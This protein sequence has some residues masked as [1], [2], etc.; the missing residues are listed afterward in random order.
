MEF[1]VKRDFLP[2]FITNLF[3]VL[4]LGITIY[5]TY[6]IGIFLLVLAIVLGGAAIYNTAVIFATCRIEAD[7]LLFK[8]GLFKYEININDIV[9]VTPSKNCH[10]SLA[11]SFDRIRIL[12]NKGEKQ[13]VYYISVNDNEKLYELISPKKKSS[14]EEVLEKADEI[15]K[16]EISTPKKATTTKA[17]SNATKKTT[18]AKPKTTKTT[19]TTKKTATKKAEK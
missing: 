1:K 5:F 7:I 15:V 19:A 10:A 11:L 2:I 14:K 6:N 18:A 4:L 8:T 13:K 9:K 17:K 16:A 12:V 3:F